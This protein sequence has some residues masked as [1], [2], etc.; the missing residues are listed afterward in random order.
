MK[1]K[2]AKDITNREQATFETG[3]KL[4]ALYHI[5]CGIPISRDENVIKSIEQGIEQ[6]ISCQPYVKDVKIKIRKEELQG[7][8]KDEFDYDEISGKMIEADVSILFKNI[9][10]KGKIEWVKD[11]EFPLMF[12]AEINEIG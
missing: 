12:I 9:E 8:K 2:F 5:L 11:L 3:I 4:G 1:V 6:S 7:E 10:I